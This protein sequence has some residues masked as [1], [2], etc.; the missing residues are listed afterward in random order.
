[1]QN[2]VSRGTCGFRGFTPERS[3]SVHSGTACRASMK[4]KLS[5]GVSDADGLARTTK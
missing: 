4:L 3:K 5:K 2:V 1:M